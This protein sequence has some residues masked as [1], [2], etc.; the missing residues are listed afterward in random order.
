MLSLWFANPG[1][2]WSLLAIPAAFALFVFAFIRRRQLVARLGNFPLLRRS[3]LIRPRTRRWKAFCILLALALVAVASAGPQWGQDPSAQYRKGRDVIV[4]LDLSRSMSA[5]QPSRRDLAILAIRDLADAFESHGGN[6]VALVAFASRPQLFFPLTQDCD[7]LRH[8]LDQIE[9][10]DFPSLRVKE[11]TSGTRFGAALKLAVSSGD[12]ERANRP[13]IVLLSDGDDPSPDEEWLAGANA[14]LEN[15]VRVHVVGIGNPAKGE[16]IPVGR[17]LLEFDGEIVRS[18][19][20]ENRLREIARRTNA[21]YWPAHRDRFPLGAYV[22]NQLDADEL[23]A[24]P[25]PATLPAYQLRY[26]WFLLLAVLLFAMAMILPDGSQP[27]LPAGRS[28]MKAPAMALSLTAVLCVSA[29]DP[30][31]LEGLLRQADEAFAEQK[32]DDAL[33]LYEQAETSTTDPGR[34]AFNKAATYY[35]LERYREAIDCYRRCLEDDAAPPERRARACFDLGNAILQQAQGDRQQLA[36]AVKAYRAAL[37]LGD[38]QASWYKGARH[39][40][41][42]AQMLWLQSP[43]KQV[44]VKRPPKSKPEKSKSED[45]KPKEKDSVLVP[46][47]PSKDFQASKSDHLPKDGKS[48]TLSSGSVPVVL[49]DREQV[50]PLTPEQTLATLEQEAERIAAARRQQRSPAGPRQLST[51]DW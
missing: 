30:P 15:N 12:P 32:F 26:A 11:P 9:A 17:D 7:H 47:D 34:V 43:D 27:R 49:P 10:S 46:V 8:T 41:E 13:V 23:R 5:E 40:L 18:H 35:R 39:N 36:E 38:A 48:E 19:L 44:E 16:T 22:L 29:A 14:A 1:L 28:R 6:R 37:H 21:E 2:L 4:V 20:N 50:A 24:E 33:R 45:K 31:A 51:K 25:M 3:L 42:L